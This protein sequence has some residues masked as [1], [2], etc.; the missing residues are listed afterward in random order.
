MQ[1]PI[2][3]THRTPRSPHRYTD[4]PRAGRL[5]ARKLGRVTTRWQQYVLDVALERVDGPGSPFA[6]SD[7]DLIVGRRGGKSATLFGVPLFRSLAGPVTLDDGRVLPFAG[8][9]T[10]QNLT[11]ARRRF[12]KDLVEPLQQSMSP[13]VWSA[14]HRLRSAIAD[15]QLT[16]DPVVAGKDWR[17]PRCST[18]SVFAPTKSSVR[19]DGLFH[20]T[21][22][23][24][25]V[26]TAEQGAELMAAAG[27]TLSTLRGHGQIWRTSNVSLLN[28]NR[29]WLYQLRDKGRAAV[30]SG[31][32]AGTA[33]FEF[34]IPDTADPDDEQT[35]WDYY[36][37]LGD[38]LVRIDELR[39][40]RERLGRDSFAAEYLGRWPSDAGTALWLALVREQWEAAATT[41]QPA[42]GTRVALG[43]DI[44]P[45]G[46]SSS[47]VAATAHPD[48]PGVL[49]E[50]IDH[51]PGSGWVADAVRALAPT[52]DVIS[53]DDYGAGHDI[54]LALQDTAAVVDRLHL[55][56]SQD[57]IAACYTF[58]AALR[59]GGLWWRR[60]DYHELLT[61]AAAAAQRTVG[62]AWQWERRVAV[63]QTPLVGATLAA[64]ALGR[65]PSPDPFYVF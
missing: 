59:E 52:V 10:A 43:V 18:I 2:L 6:Y 38:G 14:G 64:W 40:D 39:A 9:H 58:E 32:T 8:A 3:P 13:A 15:T 28:G 55:T 23:E 21:V 45:F 22:D 44:D 11:A 27:P 57:F 7:V 25:L 63:S 12:M 31:R 17:Q 62:R 5:I 19:G 49:V 48:R 61:A 16:L 33:Y 60:S 4:G 50:V 46:R 42:A 47:I 54:A 26:F 35:W 36:P 37:G 34:T 41:V 65:A 51:R 20:L 56:R 24:A 1:P 53:I 30:E 29:T